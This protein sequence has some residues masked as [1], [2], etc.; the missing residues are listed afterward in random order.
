ML[1]ILRKKGLAKKIIWAVAI[2]I[3]ISFGFLG[4]AYLLTGTGGANYAGKIFRKK[5][6]FEDYDTIYQH[7][8]IFSLIRYGD[9][10]SNVQQFLNLDA[11]TW[12]RLILLYEADKRKIKIND[13]EVVQSIEEYPFFQRD[14]QFDTLLY[15]D[16]LRYIF[17]IQPRS[18]EESIRD[19][20]KIQKLFE[21]E[22]SNVKLP[23]EKTYEEY[24]KLNEKVQISYALISSDTFKPEVSLNQEQVK[25]YYKEHRTEFIMPASVNVQYITLDLPKE[26]VDP[27]AE[28]TEAIED[29]K[30]SIREK[31]QAI[32]QELLI[33]SDMNTAASSND[34]ELKTS[35]FFSM[36]KPTTFMPYQLLNKIFQL[37]VGEISPPHETVDKIFIVK[38]I[39]RKESYVP[40]FEEAKDKVFE[41]LL[42][43]K[44][45]KIAKDKA[46]EF[47]K[48]LLEK[49]N[50][51]LTKDFPK[52][53]KDLGLEIF[54]TPSFNRGQYL[55]QIGI[56]KEFQEAAFA[57]NDSNKISKAV[58]TPI[59]FCILHLDSYVPIDEKTF[60]KEKDE[61]TNKLATE[62]KNKVFNEFLT[63]LRLKANLVDNISKQREQAAQQQTN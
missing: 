17:R 1:K 53:A 54:Q 37:Q 60:E 11:E 38:L 63:S 4:T 40:E 32:Y 39:K 33:S 42:D 26:S 2:V 5:I 25:E 24:K 31:A 50:D 21:E 34:L 15:N 27:E 62:E 45:K 13:E 58:E 3:I 30:D 44:A 43:F 55:P 10:F 19:N 14:G 23:D 61:F 16:V 57:L 47:Y 18:F 52:I 59:G 48:T 20:L 8:R 35:G 46:Q 36:E 49:Y 7:V 22:T 29:P 28:K 56:A 51:S 9:N 41:A 12:D 6:S